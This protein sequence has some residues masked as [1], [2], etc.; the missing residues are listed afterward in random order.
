MD[1]PR[2]RVKLDGAEEI[3]I[4]SSDLF[5]EIIADSIFKTNGIFIEN[6]L[7]FSDNC[8]S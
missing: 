8:K 5:S 3:Q 1:S 7:S 4:S 2:L 6:M